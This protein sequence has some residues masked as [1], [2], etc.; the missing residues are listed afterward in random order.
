MLGLPLPPP[1]L[2][3]LLEGTHFLPTSW[4]LEELQGAG[5]LSTL[6]ASHL[7]LLPGIW[8]SAPT[9]SYLHT[10]PI[11]TIYTY[12][13][14]SSLLH[15]YS[16]LSFSLSLSLHIPTL[17]LFLYI[18]IYIHTTHLPPFLRFTHISFC[19]LPLHTHTHTVSACPL[20]CLQEFPLPSLSME[21]S[22]EG[23]PSLCS[24]LHILFSPLL[25]SHLVSLPSSLFS[26]LPHTHTTFPSFTHTYHTTTHTHT[27]F[28]YFTEHLENRETLGLPTAFYPKNSFYLQVERTPILPCP[29]TH[30]RWAVAHS[31]SSL[32][33]SQASPSPP[34][35]IPGV[36]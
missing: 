23:G 14:L 9:V 30:L 31:S 12:T 6:P 13:F 8:I 3:E 18:Y 28:Y 4:D 34:L 15:T 26:S 5:G 33:L 36:V 16:L 7:C 21:F 22:G 10:H 29:H 17:C 19:T 27:G 25:V 11:Y 32:P 35:R 1:C 2:L 24:S 20:P